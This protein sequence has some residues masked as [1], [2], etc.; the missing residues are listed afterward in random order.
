MNATADLSIITLVANASFVVQCVLGIL[1]L[2]SLLSWM[3]IFSKGLV[4]SR[5]MRQTD[6]FE[7]RFWSGAD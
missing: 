1:V 7:K 6:E 2:A 3:T 4:L 5:A